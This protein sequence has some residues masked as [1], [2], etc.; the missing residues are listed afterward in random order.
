MPLPKPPGKLAAASLMRGEADGIAVEP[1]VP[2]SSPHNVERN[3]NGG[4][5]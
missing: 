4:V 2:V 5:A 3:D 1:A